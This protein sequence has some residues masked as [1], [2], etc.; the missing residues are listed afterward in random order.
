MN[1]LGDATVQC[2]GENELYVLGKLCM[3]P[4][5]HDPSASK[6]CWVPS[7]IAQLFACCTQLGCCAD[8]P[9]PTPPPACVD[10]HATCPKLKRQL[11]AIN[12]SCLTTDFGG[13]TGIAAY[14]GMHLADQCCAS[15]KPSQSSHC[16][17]CIADG[18]THELCVAIGVCGRCSYPAACARCIAADSRLTITQCRSYGL[19]CTLGCAPAGAGRRRAQSGA[20]GGAAAQVSASS[21]AWSTFDKLMDCLAGAPPPALPPACVWPPLTSR[22]SLAPSEAHPRS[23]PVIFFDVL[24]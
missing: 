11:D 4:C 8:T 10:L 3:E 15:C 24:V 1:F 21:A 9:P 18:H 16:D 7:E 23:P 2:H 12:G 13:A 19:D 5:L 14:N 6:C 20:A 22:H 17:Q